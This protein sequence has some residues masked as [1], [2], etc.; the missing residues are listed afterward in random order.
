MKMDRY[1]GKNVL[2]MHNTMRYVKL[3][4]IVSVM[5]LVAAACGGDEPEE[6]TV[7]PP[8]TQVPVT[9]V[10]PT[11]EP[12]EEPAMDG[13]L[14][15][16][17][18]LPVTGDLAFL[19][20]PEVAGARLAVADINAAGGVFG[21]D[22]VLHE[23]DSGDTNQD[24]AN[25]EVD[26]LLALDVDAIIGAASSAVSKLVIDKI[27]GNNVIQV[28]PANTSPDFTTYDDNGLYFR[29]APSDLLQGKV[30]A[31]LVASEGNEIAGVIF[32]QESYGQGLADSFKENFESQGGTVDPF[33]AY[34]PGTDNFDAE[35]DQLAGASPDAVVVIGFQES[36]T[37]LVTM[38]ERGIGPTSAT[39]VY[40]V[41]GN[42]GGIGAELSDPSIITGMRGTEPSVDLSSISDFTSRLEGAYEGGLQEI[43]AYG[44]ETYDAIVIVA[45]AALVANSDDPVAIGAQINGVTRGGTK[46]TSFAECKNII[47]S[48]SDPDYDGV[49][50]PYEFVEAGEPAAAS[51]RIATY[52]GGDKPDSALDEYVFAGGSDATMDDMEEMA[53]GQLVIGTLLPVT[54]DLAFLGPPEVAGARLAVADINAAGGVFGNDVVLHEGD[55][56][57]TNQDIANPEVDRL[58]AL[59]VD[60]IIGAASS[61]VSKLVIDKI[62][63]NNVIQV[64]PANTSPDFTTYDDNGLYFRTA[65]SDLL[66]GKVLADLVASEGNEIAGVIFRQESYGQGLADSFKENF[67][68]QGGTVDPFIAYAPG[69]DNF[70]AEVDQ[71]AGASP[72]AVVV[73]GFQESATILVTMHERGI[74]PTSA[75][76]VYGVDGNIG[77]I[78]AELSDPSIITGMRGTEPSVDL[79]SISDFT[80]R[81]E[82]AYEG[83]LQ[84]IYAYG[85]E[86]YDAIVIVALAALV[87][88]SDDPV[89]IGAQINGVTRGGFKCTSFAECK[90]I[91]E[92]GS[93]PD[94]DGV[95]GPYEFVEAGEPAAASFRI[96]TY[97]G[98]DKPDS[99]LDEYVFAAG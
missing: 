29:T 50:G 95:G 94:Y 90:N 16:G 60:A 44:A 37:I 53:T 14:V 11:V 67:E 55:S 63:G 92:S 79:S 24:I 43:Y 51:F 5:A 91:I 30:L 85:A 99:A 64:S 2:M 20:P 73:I 40:G 17:T 7:A 18:L 71:L 39:N 1:E 75:T 69:T 28:S 65:P 15:I 93:D 88:N 49:G 83:G 81:L 86:T 58:L 84:E 3:L 13:Q 82:G 25:P 8:T 41:D 46:C 87:A 31:D 21:N 74:G 47:E 26:R 9:T 6:E 19:G 76:N 23:G 72:D 77:G 80:S 54:G 35:V 89:A 22:V 52:S 33:I 27:T 98:G 38:H 78:G 32:R 57:D 61:A 36:A 4:V 97:S 59:D 62:T 56:G 66:Q 68:S 42:I 96:A 48:G 12:T 10:A 70:D 34:A 45:L